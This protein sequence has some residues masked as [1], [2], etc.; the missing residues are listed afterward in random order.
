MAVYALE[1]NLQRTDILQALDSD[2]LAGLLLLVEINGLHHTLVDEIDKQ[3]GYCG[4]QDFD[5]DFKRFFH[6]IF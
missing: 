2:R 4:Q 5:D 6:I 3:D 1:R